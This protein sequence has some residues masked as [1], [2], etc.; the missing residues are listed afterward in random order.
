M[1]S[2]FLVTLREGLEAALIIGIIMAY[3]VKTDN[4]QGLKSAWWGAIAAIA[5]SIAIGAVIFFAAGEFTGRAEEIFEGI[6][7]FIAAGFL[8]WMILWM[9]QK[10]ADI[11]SHLQTQV[12]SALTK[13]PSA[14]LFILSFIV[15]IREGIETALFL[16][17]AETTAES[18]ALFIT[19]GLVG[20][21]IAVI[22]GYVIYKGTARLNLKAF[23][24]VTSILLI[25][26][27]AGLVAHGF[28]EFH[29]AGIIP[30]VIE[31]VWDTNS[32]IADTSTFGRFLAALFGY[33]GNPSLVEV[34]A[35]FVYLIGAFGLY[36]F[37]KPQARLS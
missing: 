10:A 33:N 2:S 23:F 27:A 13:G 31:H 32:V 20:L 28:H 1:F 6:S 7:M 30:P 21:I 14:G 29:E 9:H 24:N 8:T 36:F 26:F 3:L 19:G 22:A 35:Y 17:A 25:I 15:V 37:R 34:V 12:Q 11:K 4:R 16:F 5:A 18:T